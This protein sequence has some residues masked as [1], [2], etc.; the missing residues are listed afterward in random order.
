MPYTTLTATQ[1]I[2]AAY[3]NANIRDQVVTPFATT[4][5]RDAAITVP[6]AEMIATIT[7]TNR[8][9]MYNGTAWI[10]IG[11]SL[12]RVRCTRSAVLSVANN[13]N[14]VLTGWDGETYDTDAIHDTVTNNG[15]FTIP[16]GMGG[17]WRFDANFDFAGVAAAGLRGTWSELNT[18]GAGARFGSATNTS[19]S[20]VDFTYV[21]ITD[22]ILVSAGDFVNVVVL[23]NSGGAMNVGSSSN[24]SFRAHY[25]S[26]T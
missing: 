18:T 3:G 12:P 20:G 4:A 25:I 22:S 21:N 6:V 26:A 8:V 14:T 2:T 1:D 10:T 24:T 5:A 23:Q 19:P 17:M 9:T 16:V 7:G 15:R 11:G 13:T